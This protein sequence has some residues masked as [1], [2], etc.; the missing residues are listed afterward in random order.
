MVPRLRAL[1]ELARERA[2]IDGFRWDLV[3]P[4]VYL[5]SRTPPGE[6]AA[7]LGDEGDLAAVLEDD[8][9]P[10]APQ[11]IALASRDGSKSRRDPDEDAESTVVIWP[12]RAE[13]SGSLTAAEL[14]IVG[15]TLAVDGWLHVYDGC[16][17][18]VAGDLVAHGLRCLGNVV[19][20]GEI[21]A[22]IVLGLGNGGL[23]AASQLSCRIY[24]NPQLAVHA[25][26]SARA[27]V[28][29]RDGD[30]T[31]PAGAPLVAVEA[32]LAEGLVQRDPETQRAVIDYGELERRR[33]RGGQIFRD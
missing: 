3:E 22:E 7:Q 31:R 12:G 25:R 2:T 18:V 9:P 17:V 10:C 26:V 16:T 5:W 27:A 20:L 30:W 21:D 13:V 8:C 1:D 32:L 24:D 29:D 14:L 11:W 33:Q 23:V 4:F 19:V 6:V 15:G 28:Y